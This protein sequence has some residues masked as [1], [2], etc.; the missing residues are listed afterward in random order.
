[1]KASVWG[2]LAACGVLAISAGHAMAERPGSPENTDRVPAMER[3]GEFEPRSCYT[4]GHYMT[5]PIYSCFTDHQT[6]VSECKIVGWKTH[7]IP[8]IP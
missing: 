3:G 8:L 4:T 5:C 1:M 6:Q 2:S 7:A